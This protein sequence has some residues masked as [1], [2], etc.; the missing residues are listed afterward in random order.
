[1][2]YP[3]KLGVKIPVLP[4][5]GQLGGQDVAQIFINRYKLDL[6][7]TLWD[8]F[9]IHYIGNLSVPVLTYLPV[10]A[11]F[12]T[13]MHTNVKG[14][15]RLIAFSQF[16]QRELMKWFPPAKVDC[17]PHGLNTKIFKPRDEEVKREV[18]KEIKVPEDA[19]LIIDCGANV[20]ERKQLPLLML[21][22]KEF[23]KEHPKSY[24]FLYTN[25][26]MPYPH[27]YDLNQYAK[28]LGIAKYVRYPAVTPIIEPFPD[29][30]M[31]DLYSA[32]DV[33]ATPTLGEGFGLPV[34]ESQACETPVI[35]TS[36]STMPE[37][38]GGHG[39]LVDTVPDFTFVPVW[40]PTLQQ[41]P[42]P[43]TASML[44]CLEDAY[45]NPDK[46]KKYGREARK[47]TLKYDWNEIMPSW[48][49]LLEEVEGEIGLL[50]G[51]GK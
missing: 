4:T 11:P 48:F 40:V 12:T 45:D 41:Y 31:A 46:I 51:I 37:L 34:M 44:K 38:V 24:L 13:N 16:G 42:A 8:C 10:D 43:S 28:D 1:M 30:K 3:S 39:W 25:F 20:G 21:I 15:Y 47:F 49:K 14:A 19:F 2:D 9:V 22:F 32:A 27:G 5:L 6:I 29:D 26:E 36:C 18:R 35:A 33:F 7:I 17:I 23:L 50:K